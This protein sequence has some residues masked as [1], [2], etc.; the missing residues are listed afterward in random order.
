MNT[1][2]LYAT[3]PFS[4]S[5]IA[6]KCEEKLG[7]WG[8]KSPGTRQVKGGQLNLRVPIWGKLPNQKIKN[9]INTVEQ[10]NSRL[11]MS[12]NHFLAWW[13]ISP[14]PPGKI[15]IHGL[16]ASVDPRFRP[17][18]QCQEAELFQEKTENESS[19]MGVLAVHEGGGTN[20]CHQMCYFKHA[21]TRQR[22]K[23]LYFIPNVLLMSFSGRAWGN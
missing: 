22:K 21:T 23:R 1:V 16:H 9:K 2:T 6:F 15:H 19:C 14:R 11:E 3:N 20:W 8:V 12:R 5:S 10:I 18:S 7:V 13:Q 4:G 17:S